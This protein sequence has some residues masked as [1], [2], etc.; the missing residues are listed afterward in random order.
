MLEA[1]LEHLVVERVAAEDA[2]PERDVG[3]VAQDGAGAGD[4]QLLAVVL[5]EA[6]LAHLGVE[7]G[8]GAIEEGLQHGA[9][10]DTEVTMA[11]E[12][13]PP[14]DPH[15]V[16]VLAEELERRGDDVI[17][18][19]PALLVAHL[20]GVLDTDDPVGQRGLE[21]LPVDRLLGR[22]SGA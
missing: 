6:P 18:L 22:R 5:A 17:E 1:G 8:H 14:H 21:D 19:R 9:E 2:P 7:E 15:E 3:E 20:D 13:L 4:D 10:V 12:R 16:G 11:V